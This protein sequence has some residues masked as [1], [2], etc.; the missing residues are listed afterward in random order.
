MVIAPQLL[1]NGAPRLSS[2]SIEWNRFG[3]MFLALVQWSR[4]RC[5]WSG[6]R[7]LQ[8]T[9]TRGWICT[10]LISSAFSRA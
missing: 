1:A 3:I 10:E 2:R 7:L 5:Y 8:L 6:A 9:A 4:R